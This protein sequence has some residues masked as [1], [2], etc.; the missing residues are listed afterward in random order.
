MRRG[1]VYCGLP[2]ARVKRGAKVF[3][4]PTCRAHSDLLAVDPVYGL[5]ATL[6]RELGRPLSD[7]AQLEQLEPVDAKQ[8]PR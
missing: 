4:L 5:A 7:P 1:C 3:E 6:A 2:R 8:V